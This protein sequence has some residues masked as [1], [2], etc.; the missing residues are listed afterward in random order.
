M[1]SKHKTRIIKSE[2]DVKKK[3][4]CT[5]STSKISLLV[6]ILLVGQ[7]TIYKWLK[8]KKEKSEKAL[9]PQKR[10]RKEGTGRILNPNEV[11]K[12]QELITK[13]LPSFFNLN[14]NSWIRK[15]IVELVLL[16]FKKTNGRT[17]YGRLP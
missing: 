15:A 12:I 6:S 3:Q 1:K 11:K 17:N 5:N 2:I 4:V 13:K 7:S 8:I 10:S 9:T 16:K 14:F